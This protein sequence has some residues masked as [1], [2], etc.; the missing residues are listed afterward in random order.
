VVRDI[1]ARILADGLPDGVVLNVNIP[2]PP[3]RGIRITK[4]GWK[5]YDPEIIEKQ[6]PR[7]NAY[8]WIGTGHPSHV[9][10]RDSDVKTVDAGWISIT[11]IHTDVTA[12]DVRR[13]RRI[14]ALAGLR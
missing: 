6:D 12:H 1:A 3:V 8:Y 11:P 5:Y 2:A 10:D 13:N 9:G 14:R 4:L 7:D